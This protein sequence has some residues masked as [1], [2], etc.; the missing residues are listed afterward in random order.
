MNALNFDLQ[1]HF[2]L[3]LISASL[4]KSCPHNNF[5]TNKCNAAKFTEILYNGKLITAIQ[6]E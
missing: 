3:L 4:P 6:Y 2:L 1:G 5:R